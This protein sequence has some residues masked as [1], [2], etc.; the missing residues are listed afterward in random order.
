MYRVLNFVEEAFLKPDG[1]WIQNASLRLY[2]VLKYWSWLLCGS[3][4]QGSSFITSSDFKTQHFLNGIELLWVCIL[5]LTDRVGLRSKGW[6]M[7]EV[8]RRWEDPLLQTAAYASWV[9]W[10]PYIFKQFFWRILEVQHTFYLPF[11]YWMGKFCR[12]SWEWLAAFLHLFG[13]HSQMLVVSSCHALFYRKSHISFLVL[14][15]IAKL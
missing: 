6:R 4:A 7:H 11:F 14:S 12:E 9:F 5:H 13:W 1:M 2:S 3:N 10:V 15:C 8:H